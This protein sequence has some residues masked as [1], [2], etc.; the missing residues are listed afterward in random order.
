MSGS[1]LSLRLFAADSQVSY[2]FSSRGS[3]SDVF[4]PTLIIDVVPEP[5]SV[6]LGSLGAVIIFGSRY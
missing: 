1:D 3:G 2:L 4:R 6:A 5:G